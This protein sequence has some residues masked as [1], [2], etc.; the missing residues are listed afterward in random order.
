MRTKV[1]DG[2]SK[3]AP[4]VDET[5]ALVLK[6]LVKLVFEHIVVNEAL[7]GLRGALWAW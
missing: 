1:G 6:S 4:D 5:N 2:T 7:S 3:R